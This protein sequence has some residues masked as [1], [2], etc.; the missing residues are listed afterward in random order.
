[1]VVA[2]RKGE[3]GEREGERRARGARKNEVLSKSESVAYEIVCFLLSLSL[4]VSFSQCLLYFFQRR[5]S[6]LEPSRPYF[7]FTMV[8]SKL[9][10]YVRSAAASIVRCVFLVEKT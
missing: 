3:K 8:A 2:S 7:N 4:L 9:V 10:G 6:F 5:L 1:M